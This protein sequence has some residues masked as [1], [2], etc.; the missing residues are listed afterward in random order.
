MS[1]LDLVRALARGSNAYW[2]RRAR[3]LGRRSVLHLGHSDAEY[4]AVTAWQKDILFPLLIAQL[5]G[6]ERTVLD[7]GCGPGR[8]TADLARLINGRAIGVDPIGALL[9]QAPPAPNVEY[10][11]IRR[12]RLPVADQSVDVIW[13]AV[14]L[15]MIRGRALRRAL[16]EL[17]R[18]IAPGG[19]LFLIENTTA[20]PSLKQIEFRSVQQY[21]ELVDFAALEHVHDYQDLGET[22]SVLT[23]RVP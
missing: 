4:E 21:K 18:V 22:I 8:F 17:R 15:G 20:K 7:F 2:E 16:S 10:R 13:C 12:G 1:V 23:G 6:R 14:V 11:R 3:K 5:N 9:E 19:L